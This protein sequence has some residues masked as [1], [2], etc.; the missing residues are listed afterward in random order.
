MRL[1]PVHIE[2]NQKVVTEARKR[3][4]T[5]LEQTHPSHRTA[6]PSIILI[7]GPRI[8]HVWLRSGRRKPVPQADAYTEA[9]LEAH[10]WYPADWPFV[11]STLL[12]PAP[13][14][15]APDADEV[16]NLAWAV[17]AATAEE[18]VQDVHA[19]FSELAWPTQLAVLYGV[20]TALVRSV[21]DAGT[22]EMTA[23]HRA[24][25]ADMARRQLIQRA[26]RDD[27]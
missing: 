9:G 22:G 11:L 1:Q 19:L 21:A 20:A 14:P 12:L 8:L 5:A 23:E 18:R 4:F 3:G 6:D 17:V 26:G 16:S 25:V 27:G 15:V 10:V 7:R 24:M 13:E 2:W